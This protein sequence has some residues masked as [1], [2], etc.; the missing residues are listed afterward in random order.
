MSETS[1]VWL[2][3]AFCSVGHEHILYYL[4]AWLSGP[5][6]YTV[7]LAG[8]L[9]IYCW[10]TSHHTWT[11]SLPNPCTMCATELDSFWGCW[12]SRSFVI[13]TAWQSKFFVCSKSLDFG[14]GFT[15]GVYTTPWY[16]KWFIPCVRMGTRLYRRLRCQRIPRSNYGSHTS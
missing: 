6:L 13:I 11:M 8:N 3:S 14:T 16:R 9:L 4:I 15:G 7:F 10:W 12:R 5:H 1:T 2:S